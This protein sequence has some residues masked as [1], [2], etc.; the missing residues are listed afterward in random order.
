ML[1]HRMSERLEDTDDGKNKIFRNSLVDNILDMCSMCDHFNV[2]G[3]QKITALKHRLESVLKGVDAG[4]LRESDELRKSVKT[5]VDS[6]I[7]D[8]L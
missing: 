1:L 5:S 8:L 6:I 2:D 7:F 4:S 3:D